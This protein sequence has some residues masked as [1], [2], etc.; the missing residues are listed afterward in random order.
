[1]PQVS[2]FINESYRVCSIDVT[3]ETSL[4]Q[5]AAAAEELDRIVFSEFKFIRP[6][7]MH[8]SMIKGGFKINFDLNWKD[9]AMIDRAK[10]DLKP[11][12]EKALEPYAEKPSTTAALKV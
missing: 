5:L 4:A 1:M 11:A 6:K 8:F 9:Q 7:A 2:V 12:L 3:L 10:N